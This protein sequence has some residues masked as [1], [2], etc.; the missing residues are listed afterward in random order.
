MAWVKPST[1]STFAPASR[2]T[3]AQLLVAFSAGDLALEVGERLD[4]VVVGAG[5]DDALADRVRLGEVVLGLALVVDRHLVGDHVEA[6]GLQRR[7]DRIPR[8][9]DEFDSDAE[10]LAD[11]LGDVDVVAGELAVAGSW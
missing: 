6:V 10:L 8:R 1:A 4:R 2:A 5:D 9:L 11:G 7:E 3:S